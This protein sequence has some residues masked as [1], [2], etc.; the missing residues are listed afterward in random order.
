MDLKNF[1]KLPKVG[2]LTRMEGYEREVVTVDR[3]DSG[4]PKVGEKSPKVEVHL[5]DGLFQI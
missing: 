4:P 2:G 5:K 3:K 1:K